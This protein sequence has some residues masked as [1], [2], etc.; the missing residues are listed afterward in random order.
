[1]PDPVHPV[2]P[3]ADESGD[4][5]VTSQDLMRE[6]PG[7]LADELRAAADT[8]PPFAEQLGVP[9]VL[10]HRMVAV[11]ADV[12]AAP[13][14]I[15]SWEHDR[16]ESA[17]KHP[18][19]VQ[20]WA[21]AGRMTLIAADGGEVRLTVLAPYEFLGV[22]LGDHWPRG[23]PESR[24]KRI[25]TATARDVGD[26]LT[27]P[28]WLTRTANISGGRNKQL[29]KLVRRLRGCC[30]EIIVLSGQTFGTDRQRPGQARPYDHRGLVGRHGW[31]GQL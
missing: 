10:D 8:D 29:N 3:D 30:P 2:P 7:H 14:M 1:M 9:A 4:E 16:I 6:R 20:T 31:P 26:V 13:I 5:D 21:R 12:G 18:V 19:T 23:E 27:F 11:E 17:L 15:H 24:V 22:R 28:A 25:A